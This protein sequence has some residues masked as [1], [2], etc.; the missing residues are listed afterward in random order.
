MPAFNQRSPYG[1][2]QVISIGGSTYE[3]L[4]MLVGPSFPVTQ[5]LQV[6]GRCVQPL[7]SGWDVGIMQQ[8]NAEV[9]AGW[10]VNW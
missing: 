8:P 9:V 10:L 6:R 5:P 3:L 7:G 1:Y 4:P 2:W